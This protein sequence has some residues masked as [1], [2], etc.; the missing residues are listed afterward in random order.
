MNTENKRNKL[1]E[2]QKELSFSGAFYA[3]KQDEII[4]GS[5]GFRNRAE[6]LE[7]Q[8]DTRFGIAS[9]CKLFTAIAVAKLVEMGKLSF[10]TKLQDCVSEEFPYFDKDITIHHLLTHTSGV[11]DY[12]DEE[13]MDDFELLWENFPMYGVRTPKDFLPLFQHR[14]M[15]GKPGRSFQY[16]N[17]GYILLGLIVEQAANYSFPSFVEENIF[18]AA[19]MNDS[20]YFEMDCLPERTALGYVEEPNGKWKTNIYS[21]PARGGSD[22]GAYVTVR[23]MAK[24]WD[25]LTGYQ[26]LSEEMTREV[27]QA[28]ECVDE[29]ENIY[30][31]Y[32]GYMELDD[33]Q[34]VIKYI[35]MG[36]D[37]G[38]NFRAVHYP[39]D[40]K[41]MIV[42]SNE[43]EGAYELL[44]EMERI[45]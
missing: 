3:K 10:E 29:E 22:G 27:L 6:K 38:V 43:S 2:V 23:D 40:E 18:K 25:A 31:G 35:Q 41:T 16:N 24:F 8:V 33:N 34:E 4:T 5:S 44:K 32:S 13:E 30:Y 19:G 20:G 14:E 28:R 9:G 7:N 36:Y 11:P 42:C 12:F 37:P 26:L 45:M 17:S 21:I 1:M 15:Q 39:H